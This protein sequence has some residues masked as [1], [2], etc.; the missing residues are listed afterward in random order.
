MVAMV[1]DIILPGY[2][3]WATTEIGKGADANMVLFNQVTV[4]VLLIVAV[5]FDL[6]LI[7]LICR[8]AQLPLDTDLRS[9]ASLL[10]MFQ[11]RFVMTILSP[12]S[13]RMSHSTTLQRWAIS[14]SCIP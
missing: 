10:I 5:S 3:G 9:S 13:K 14:V 6:Y 12:S 11:A 8:L 2:I 7:L 4:I 1:M